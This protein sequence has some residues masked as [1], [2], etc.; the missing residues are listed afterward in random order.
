[1]SFI[2]GVVLIKEAVGISHIGLCIF[3]V[4]ILITAAM[5]IGG[6]KLHIDGYHDFSDSKRIFGF[7]ISLVGLILLA[8]L[9][10]FVSS[11]F[12]INF[13]DDLKLTDHTGMYEVTVTDSVDMNEFQEC[14]DIIKYENGV[15][16]IKIKEN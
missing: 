3:G 6:A 11:D 7:I 13:L 10:F 9:G 5:M 1:M 14:Y 12:F 15:Y 2:K 8:S 4:M 16:T